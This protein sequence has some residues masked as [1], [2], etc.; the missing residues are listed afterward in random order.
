MT[1]YIVI[2][3]YDSGTYRRNDSW[4]TSWSYWSIIAAVLC[5]Y[6]QVSLHPSSSTGYVHNVPTMN[7]MG[8]PG[9]SNELPVGLVK[10]LPLSE[11]IVPSTAL[12]TAP[13]HL[14]RHFY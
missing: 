8:W 12:S 14:A 7:S 10:C 4:Y 5:M 2:Q 6:P 3:S 11:M 1:L 9:L 13:Q